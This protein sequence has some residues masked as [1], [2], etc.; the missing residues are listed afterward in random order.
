MPEKKPIVL[1]RKAAVLLG[2]LVG[3]LK[4]KMATDA[5]VN[6]YPIMA[7]LKK[8][9][10]KSQEK[11]IIEGLSKELDGKLA[12][13][14]SV[15][16]IRELIFAMDAEPA[17]LEPSAGPMS[18]GKEAKDNKDDDDDQAEDWDDDDEEGKDGSVSEL[19]A[20]EGEDPGPNGPVNKKVGT[21]SGGAKDRSARS[22]M[23][24][25]KAITQ[26]AL[27]QALS[28]VTK[29]VREQERGIREAEKFV[30]PWVGE[31]AADLAMDSAEDVYRH[32]LTILK[33]KDAETLPGPALRTVL[34]YVPK[35]GSRAHRELERG[36]A[37]GMDSA[38]VK[39]FDEYFPDAKRI[40]VVG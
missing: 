13:D 14:A 15:E 1:S 9:D 4:P 40:G 12:E 23:G 27:D 38:H 19:D 35:P 11:M 30:R 6:F 18:G 5:K 8:G 36:S 37:M 21:G 2:A 34:S 31:L 28:S 24:K 16:D 29:T 32:A 26:H 33:V 3:Y 39:S 25:D 22:M 10:F 17:C 20:H 7:G